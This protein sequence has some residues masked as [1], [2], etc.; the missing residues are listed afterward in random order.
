MFT[1]LGFERISTGAAMVTGS[2]AAAVSLGASPLRRYH[3]STPL[4]DLLDIL[5]GRIGGMM[6]FVAVLGG[7]A[8][9]VAAGGRRAHLSRAGGLL[10][11]TGVLLFAARL[12]GRSFGYGS[13][14]SFETFY[15]AFTAA[16]G[17]IALGAPLVVM[18]D[19]AG[20]LAGGALM[21]FR[22]L[23]EAWSSRWQLSTVSSSLD[24][25]LALSFILFGVAPYWALAA[26]FLCGMLHGVL[27]EV[28]MIVGS[29]DLVTRPLSNRVA[30]AVCFASL[31]SIVLTEAL[32]LT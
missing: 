14:V 24:I 26:A 12:A 9:V 31:G 10:L 3:P 17:S 28:K 4:Y 15:T 8:L 21:P 18:G 22:A 16:A 2:Y 19:V 27:T 11:K 30:L 13:A 7:I 5:L 23:L 20:K 6:M 29:E 1:M 32:Q 25:A